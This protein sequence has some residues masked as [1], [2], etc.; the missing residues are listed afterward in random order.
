MIIEAEVSNR[1]RGFLIM[2]LDLYMWKGVHF[3]YT[4]L[5]SLLPFQGQL[6]KMQI[7]H[8]LAHTKVSLVS[9]RDTKNGHLSL[10]PLHQN[11]NYLL[12]TPVQA[13]AQVS[14]LFLM[15]PHMD[16]QEEYVRVSPRH[17]KS[18]KWEGTSKWEGPG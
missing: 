16:A 9:V 12:W 4:G 13:G 1:V 14:V 15:M 3:H 5:S 11:V 17:T 6:C 18:S 7:W 2:D 8:Q 10:I